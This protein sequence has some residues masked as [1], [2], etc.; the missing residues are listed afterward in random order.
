MA[1]S[2]AIRVIMSDSLFVAL[3]AWG[4]VSSLDRIA[5]ALTFSRKSQLAIEFAYLLHRK[6]N[7]ISIF[8]VNGSNAT[9]FEESYREI[10]RRASILS[11]EDKITKVLPSVLNWLKGTACGKWLMIVDNADD[12]DVFSCPQTLDTQPPKGS[13]GA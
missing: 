12:G 2:L 3:G 5:V 13:E 7:Q 11:E 8:W 9:M 6:N 4:R 10:A 1:N